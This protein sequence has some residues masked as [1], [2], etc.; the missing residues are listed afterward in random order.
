L[1]L[2]R[3][4]ARPGGRD[5][6]EHFALAL[7]EHPRDEGLENGTLPF[8][9]R[10]LRFS[11]SFVTILSGVELDARRGDVEHAQPD[12]CPDAPI[13]GLAECQLAGGSVLVVGEE[14]R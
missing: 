8:A 12:G 6:Q 14:L 7:V 5:L 10:E 3:L 11:R 1:D 13:L 4:V 2:A 9:G